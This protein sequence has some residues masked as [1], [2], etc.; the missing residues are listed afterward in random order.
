MEDALLMMELA[1][2]VTAGLAAPAESAQP[3]QRR[4]RCIRLLGRF[5]ETPKKNLKKD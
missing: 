4:V 5:R 1:A 2:E 3:P